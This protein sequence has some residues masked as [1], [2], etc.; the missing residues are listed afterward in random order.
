MKIITFVICDD[1][2]REI[3]NKHSLMGVYDGKINFNVTPDKKDSWPKYMKIGIFAVFDFEE[4]KPHSLTINMNYNE[5]NQL[6]GTAER[7][8]PDDLEK[9][10]CTVAVVLSDF[11]FHEPGSIK[12]TFDF[13]D[14]DKKKIKTLSPDFEL[15][16]SELV[17]K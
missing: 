6:L 3:G 15:K 16:I 11:R 12:F 5:K 7:G 10:K 14:A 2:R 13:F 4:D 1:I 8:K 17:T 9:N